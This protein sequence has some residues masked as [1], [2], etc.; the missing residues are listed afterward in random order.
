LT[1]GGTL[2]VGH[3]I[4]ATLRSEPGFEPSFTGTFSYGEDYLTLDSS[5]GISRPGLSGVVIPDDGSAPFQMQV[6][7]VQFPDPTLDAIVASNQT[8]NLAI[9]YGA[10]YSGKTTQYSGHRIQITL[11][12]FGLPLSAAEAQSTQTCRTAYLLEARLLATVQISMNFMWD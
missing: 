5:D 4:S 1:T 6:T 8:K 2:A 11:S 3:V 9:P 10:V 12:Q 7:G